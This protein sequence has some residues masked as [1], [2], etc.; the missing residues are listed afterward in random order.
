MRTPG[1]VDWVSER[2]GIWAGLE[3]GCIC[4]VEK[5]DGLCRQRE[6]PVQRGSAKGLVR[7]GRWEVEG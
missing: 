3:G 5:E 6:Q 1:A 7:W 4:P 2:T